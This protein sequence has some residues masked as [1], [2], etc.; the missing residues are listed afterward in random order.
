MSSV[1]SSIED[2]LKNCSSRASLAQF[3]VSHK[4]TTKSFIQQFDNKI[5]A[6]NNLV[7]KYTIAFKNVLPAR[8]RIT[9]KAVYLGI[10]F[11]EAR[12]E[13]NIQIQMYRALEV[14]VSVAKRAATKNLTTNTNTSSPFDERNLNTSDE[15]MGELKHVTGSTPDMLEYLQSVDHNCHSVIGVCTKVLIVLFHNVD[16]NFRFIYQ[17]QLDDDV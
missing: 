16:P 10:P 5:Q 2:Y 1:V 14:D 12:L 17:I 13:R 9:G 3:V 7:N 4:E 6:K 15:I 8:K 11:A